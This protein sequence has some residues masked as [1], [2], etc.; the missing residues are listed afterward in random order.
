MYFITYLRKSVAFSARLKTKLSPEWYLDDPESNQNLPFQIYRQEYKSEVSKQHTFLNRSM[1]N[2]NTGTWLN[3]FL[4]FISFVIWC[5]L[6]I[7]QMTKQFGA[8]VIISS[9][10]QHKSNSMS[11]DETQITH[12]QRA[13]TIKCSTS[14]STGT[15]DITNIGQRYLYMDACPWPG[16]IG[17]PST[18]D[19]HPNMG[20]VWYNNSWLYECNHWTARQREGKCKW[21]KGIE[22][23]KEP[24]DAAIVSMC[25]AAHHTWC[26]YMY[27]QCTHR[28][29][30]TRW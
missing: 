5:L 11:N 24:N 28:W 26:T 3:E 16:K 19:F 18:Q 30:I 15:G 25:Y 17:K 9:T 23:R 2:L 7:W 12:W 29:C 14:R 8:N 20:E 22:D 21:R 13:S 27:M 4:L 10:K 6:I 1:L